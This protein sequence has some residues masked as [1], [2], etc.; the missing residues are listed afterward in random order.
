MN[1]N[2][3]GVKNATSLPELNAE[4]LV[5][6]LKERYHRAYQKVREDEGGSGI[7]TW[8]G[9]VLLAVNPYQHM[10]VYGE[11]QIEHHFTKTITQADPH[12]FG[13]ASHAYGTLNKTRSAQSIV[14]SGESGAGKT[15]TAKY[16]MRFLS[17]IGSKSSSSSDLISEFLESTNPI[18]EAFGNAKTCRNENSSRFGK[19]MK[20]YYTLP[21][22]AAAIGT[23]HKLV[24]ASVETYLLARSRVTHTP[25]NERNYHV[26]YLVSNGGLE[27]YLPEL[28]KII[29]PAD[30]FEYLS[31]SAGITSGYLSDSA[32]LGQVMK[33][34]ESL[35]VPRH[36]QLALFELVLGLLWMGNIQLESEDARDPASRSRV[37]EKSRPALEIC[38]K[39][40]DIQAEDVNL[41]KLLTEQK[42]SIGS[43]SNKS[44]S[45]LWTHTN[46]GKA[47]TVRDAV[48][49]RVYAKL[50]DYIVSL[51]NGKLKGNME[52]S[53][54]PQSSSA[55]PSSIS[56]LDIF[57][58]ENLP[59]NG[60]EQLCINYAN[61]RL[62]N[63]FLR[64]VVISE[65]EEYSRECIP[66]PGV[67]PPDN[68]P[69]I[70][71]IAGRGG[72]FD[73]LKKTTTD[74]MLRPLEGKEY[75]SEFYQTLGTATVAAGSTLTDIVKIQMISSGGPTTRRM[76]ANPL[77]QMFT[78][79]HYAEEVPYTVEAFVE[80][81]KDSDLRVDFILGFM[82]N[83]LLKDCLNT[84]IPGV[85]DDGAAT[86][87]QRRCI[88]T[89][90]A[91]QVDHL[92][93]DHLEKT[94][95]HCIRCL[96]PNDSK[97]PN[98][99]DDNRV[100][101]QLRVSGMFEVLTLMAHAY[102]IRMAYNDL[103]ARYRPL[104][105][106]KIMAELTRQTGAVT[107]P[108]RKSGGR[109]SLGGSS[110]KVH[111][112]TARLFVQEAI[113]LLV[114][115]VDTII[116]ASQ[117]T[118][119]EDFQ[120]GTSKVF[121]RLGKVD[122]LEKLL[123]ICDADKNTAHLVADLIGKRIMAKRRARQIGFVRTC[124]KLVIIYRKRQ[125][126]WKWFYLYFVRLTFLVK[127]CKKVY[128]PKI[129][130]RR[131]RKQQAATQIQR[132]YR[133][134]LE[135]V[136][137][138]SAGFITSILQRHLALRELSGQS[139]LKVQ[140]HDSAEFLQNRLSV[141]VAQKAI[142]GLQFI[143]SER[144][145]ALELEELRQ[146]TI[147]KEK[148]IEETRILAEQRE[149]AERA[150]IEESK[151]QMEL[152]SE[153]IHELELGVAEKLELIQSIKSQQEQQVNELHAQI[154][155]SE[156]IAAD[157]IESLRIEM[158]TKQ[159][160]WD[161]VVLRD[162]QRIQQLELQIQETISELEEQKNISEKFSADIALRESE[163]EE[164][165]S[166]HA[167]I[168]HEL[169]SSHA[170]AVGVLETRLT[171]QMLEM[172]EIRAK[173]TAEIE[174]IQSVHS[175][176]LSE[177]ESQIE[178]KSKEID[179]I[180]SQFE[181][182]KENILS[183]H[184]SV[185][186]GLETA[187]SEKSSEFDRAAIAHNEQIDQIQFNHMNELDS[188]KQSI[189]AKES[190]LAELESKKTELVNSLASAEA[191]IAEKASELE[192]S[193]QDHELAV[194]ALND[195]HTA[196]LDRVHLAAKEQ[197]AQLE[198]QLDSVRTELQNQA[199]M[200]KYTSSQHEEAIGALKELNRQE[201]ER[202]VKE[203]EIDVGELN[204]KMADVEKRLEL[205]IAEHEEK[206]QSL[207]ESAGGEL[208]EARSELDRVRAELEQTVSELRIQL[209]SS[210]TSLVAAKAAH[211]ES[212]NQTRESH[213][214]ELESVRREMEEKRMGLVGKIDEMTA[215]LGIA[216]EAQSGLVGQLEELKNTYSA[217]FAT[218]ERVQS[219]KQA[220]DSEL[221]AAATNMAQM[222]G[223]YSSE[224]EKLRL[225][226][227]T[228]MAELEAR[229]STAEQQL[230]QKS[231]DY[232][233]LEQLL[234]RT[235]LDSESIREEYVSKLETQESEKIALKTSLDEQ[236]KTSESIQSSLASL[237]SEYKTVLDD[238]NQ[239]Q[240]TVASLRAE[241]LKLKE[242]LDAVIQEKAQLAGVVSQS[243]HQVEK[244]K[245]ETEEQL[246]RD[247]AEMER[248]IANETAR[249]KKD[250]EI[251]NKRVLEVKVHEV[252]EMKQQ[253]QTRLNEAERIRN[254]AAES[255]TRN[256]PTTHVLAGVAKNEVVEQAINDYRSSP[257]EYERAYVIESRKKSHVNEKALE[258][259]KRGA[260]EAKLHQSIAPARMPMS[261]TRSNL[262]NISS[263]TKPIL[264]PSRNPAAKMPRLSPSAGTPSR[265]N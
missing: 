91:T 173:F 226:H 208:D 222:T 116:P 89:T 181:A 5:R 264:S 204:G 103:F 162:T 142:I 223:R 221:A 65:A 98:A 31:G 78:V 136:R 92:L 213:V 139:K 216:E 12:P 160:E 81:N 227:G 149:A 114:Q 232:T 17:T 220:V 169:T 84:E 231:H 179:E 211:G 155:A 183:N 50:F 251:I 74:S 237:E 150:A 90:F 26:F 67:N 134:H 30:Q 131:I 21:N 23:H 100:S 53:H 229:I 207:A 186:S 138:A 51:L 95:L 151:R 171:E 129:K 254:E 191:V 194:S 265:F 47:R 16:V 120:F 258:E 257:D 124:V 86:G 249:Y 43:S 241:G 66:Y 118:H 119:G 106:E 9:T 122:P 7:Y 245:K 152:A 128:I 113:G 39:I 140:M 102:P 193:I 192:K 94:R 34:F 159:S 163:L 206:I 238:R 101:N 93:V 182:E 45:S 253:I 3:W 205:T 22:S 58:F 201:I 104:L 244:I 178:Q 209:E 158:D 126:Y 25:V 154:E 189:L 225:T 188:M 29:R 32:F 35:E 27:K 210:Q 11:G 190:E 57:G 112:A 255:I 250:M 85:V 215:Q 161:S 73:L 256:T 167:K 197:Q 145:R 174:E 248:R 115:G 157:T 263:Q 109:R 133:A 233:Q 79:C 185:V 80:S 61:E 6:N 117:L 40:F 236:I 10:D 143:A 54:L 228:A 168:V 49:K 64:N 141:F 82:G 33:A 48:V 88:A 4:S 15:E 62:Q 8:T 105:S 198:A 219:E 230:E 172:D 224:L 83:R 203:R 127:V 132:A 76:S 242:Q 1:E 218:L 60:L 166:M 28:A 170:A 212:I 107:H 69:V 2:F 164:A 99:F 135:R 243:L 38:A 14:V 123:A 259:A 111:G 180:R 59:T 165:R 37:S 44:N 240:S 46:V 156:K 234:E 144:R 41:E 148:E 177:L 217:T 246:K 247:R 176:R 184:A 121:F 146:E 195:A 202:M 153:K 260:L 252:E 71:A 55:S 125:A 68:G 20:L 75:D 77:N 200:F 70:R 19:I 262:D 261:P 97:K 130:Q 199:D 147:R 235:K 96:K 24:S 108:G 13:I 175:T 56:I 214:S 18:L 36:D 52:S 239:L 63:F 187:L 87:Q 110:G 42:L 196:D 72:I 137:V